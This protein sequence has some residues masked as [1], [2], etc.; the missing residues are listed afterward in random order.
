MTAAPDVDWERTVFTLIPPDALTRGLGG[1]VLDRFIGAGFTPVAS[2][3]V[4]KR[5]QNLD[6]YNARNITEVWKAYLYRMVDLLFAYGPTVALLMRDDQPPEELT[7]HQRMRQ[8]KGASS[9]SDALPGTIRGDLRAINVTCDLVHASDTPADSQHEAV[10]FADELGWSG[11]AGDGAR[12]LIGLTMAGYPREERGFDQV[13]ACVRA[14]VAGAVWADLTPPGQELA[15][16]WQGGQV[17]EIAAPG[18][19]AD[20]A[21]LLRD[22]GHHPLAPLLRCEFQPD[23]PRVDL[24]GLGHVLRGFGGHLDRWEELVLT[25]SMWFR[26]LRTEVPDSC[27]V[28][29]R[30]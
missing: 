4:W 2:A 11:L 20:L 19:G 9:P 24:A 21:A 27:A 17:A 13:L 7:S 22:P 25:S 29:V 6:E 1:Q 8:L 28:S 26:P 14:R 16:S 12:D 5:P 10:S 18:A 3:V 15:L 23:S 30:V